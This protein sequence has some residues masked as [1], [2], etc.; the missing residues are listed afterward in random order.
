L[1]ALERYIRLEATGLWRETPDTPPREVV[2]S[3]GKATL[4]LFRYRHF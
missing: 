4:L 1:T 2:V 3:F